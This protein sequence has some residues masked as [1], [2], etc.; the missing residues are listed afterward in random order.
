MPTPR[1]L[2]L[3]SL[4]KK[5]GSAFLAADDDRHHLVGLTTGCIAADFVS[6]LGGFPRGRISEVFGW[7]S[8]GKTTLCVAACAA[9]QRAGRYPV[10]LDMERGLDLTHAQRMGFD[11]TDDKKGLYVSP[12]TF[13]EAARLVYDL[14]PHADLIVVDSVPALTPKAVL[15]ADIEEMGTIASQARALAF[16]LQRIVKHIEEHNVC[17]VLVNQMRQN[18]Q[19]RP[20]WGARPSD[21]KTAG[22]AA[23]RF[24]SSL[25]LELGQV[26]KNHVTRKDTDM[27]TGKDVEIPVASLHSIKA[28]KNKVGTPYRDARFV[29]RFDHTTGIYGIDNLQTVID[30]AVNAGVI[31]TKGG[32]YYN[33]AAGK[34]TPEEVT[35]SARAMEGLYHHLSEHPDHFA[36][37]RKALSD[38]EI[39]PVAE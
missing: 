32:G 12:D 24:Y 2:A 5:M 10:Y 37:V 19:T 28:F 1:E 31:E 18:I 20:V 21:E 23:L 17:L 8:S 16:F 35:F 11:I 3:N 26:K 27:F 38:A 36:A 39:L 9:A 15:D 25:R 6:G 4:R 33:F 22:G 29:I 13:E 34:G 14:A 30:M 7:E